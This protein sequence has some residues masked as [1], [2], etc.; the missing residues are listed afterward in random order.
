[1]PQSLL[2]EIAKWIWN[3]PTTIL[4]HIH[5]KG[6]IDSVYIEP[7]KITHWVVYTLAGFQVSQWKQKMGGLHLLLLCQPMCNIRHTKMETR[8]VTHWPHI[9]ILN[10]QQGHMYV[11]TVKLLADHRS[12][13]SRKVTAWLT[14]LTSHARFV[15]F[16]F[17]STRIFVCCCWL[18]VLRVNLLGCSI[19]IGNRYF[20]LPLL[21]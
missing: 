4:L 7:S 1:M 11:S 3:G 21:L 14:I 5:S 20:N 17:F 6:G 13:S 10:H 18:D 8:N 19:S 12:E 2:R 9:Y 16:A 15:S